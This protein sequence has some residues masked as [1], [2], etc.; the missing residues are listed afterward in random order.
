MICPNCSTENRPSAK[1]CD[2]CGFPLTGLIAKAAEEGISISS[3]TTA[4]LHLNAENPE[5]ESQPEEAGLTL[6]PIDIVDE[7]A[8][9]EEELDDGAE[10]IEDQAESAEEESAEETA[11]ELRPDMT[12]DGIHIEDGWPDEY[13]FED[14]ANADAVDEAPAPGQD[15]SGLDEIAFDENYGERLATLAESAVAPNWR[16]GATI[17]MPRIEGAESPK[18]KEY[19]ASS[20]RE[21]SKGKKI[22]IGVIAGVLLV[23]AI[24]AFATYR[25]ELWGGKSIPD[26]TNMTQAEATQLLTDQGFKVRAEQVK[27]DDTEGLVLIC[28]PG[29]GARANSDEEVVIHVASARVIPEIVGKAKAEAETIIGK[30]ELSNVVF[31]QERSDEPEGQILSVEPAPGTR[32]KSATPVVVKVAEPY[33]V[34]DISGMYL[35]DA[36]EAI[37]EAGLVSWVLYVNTTDYPDGTIIGTDPSVHTVVTHDT[38][39]AILIARA[40]GAELEQAAR[41]FLTEGATVSNG[42]YTYRIDSLNSV[43][44]TGDETVAYSAVATPFVYV[45]GQTVYGSPE[46]ISGSIVFDGDNNVVSMS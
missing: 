32:V 27:S 6:P 4:E 7:D 25:M 18:R 15:L 42:M 13:A 35:D 37:E 26:V 43:V 3:A 10:T 33:R 39:V 38:S 22:A 16:D 44:Y 46:T 29:V 21:R 40:R 20:S 12:I 9:T 41:S 1:F 14:S 19:L 28:D 2:E 45:F 30:E 8:Q 23:A 11:V 34:P 31:E 24:V 36:M 5:T 17:E